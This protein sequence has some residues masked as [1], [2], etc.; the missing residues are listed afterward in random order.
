M[1]KTPSLLRGPR[2]AA[3]STPE[4]PG[5]ALEPGCRVVEVGD[6]LVTRF[7]RGP[8]RMAGPPD[9]WTTGA[10][11]DA[12]GRLVA[13]SQRP[14]LG[15]D[16]AP[17]AADPEVVRVPPRARRLE[18]R[19][20]YAGHWTNHFG[21][22]L[23]ETLSNLWPDPEGVPLDGLVAHR[24]VYGKV[25][26][27]PGDLPDTATAELSSWHAE[28]LGLAGYGDLPVEV[29][30]AQP[31]RVGHLRVPSRSL[32]LKSW[33]RPEAAALWRRMSSRV[34]P[35]GAPRVFLSR[36]LFHAESTRELTVAR[37]DAAWD[38]QLEER[39][40]AAGFAVVHPETLSIPE[41]LSVV[42]GAEVLAGS[43]GSA[44]H[45]S[46]FAEPGTR[47][48][49]IGDKRAADEPL[50]TQ[51]MIDAACGHTSAF[52]GYL[53]GRALSRYL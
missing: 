11:H 44:L 51:R 9:L 17:V 42:R 37:K 30:R 4:A 20:Q 18:G 38:E 45:L 46:A 16:Q 27:R 7:A 12:D 52:V 40:G 32:V 43:S 49:E 8:L 2:P 14:W 5:P 31:L 53:D 35:G 21:H 36:R 13:E 29:V 1:P 15:D 48:L 39:F 34:E 28:L 50:P 23:L 3:W 47:V 41:Q 33:A 26:P 25:P 22:F 19:W 24:S 10:V 6:A